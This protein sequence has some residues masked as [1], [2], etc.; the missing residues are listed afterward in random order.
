[1]KCH[2]DRVPIRFVAHHLESTVGLGRSVSRSVHTYGGKGVV[3]GSDQT[4][5]ARTH[6]WTLSGH[7]P[8]LFL[9]APAVSPGFVVALARYTESF[10]TP[11]VSVVCA[12]VPGKMSIPVS[13]YSIPGTVWVPCAA[14]LSTR[15]EVAGACGEWARNGRSLLEELGDAPETVC[16]KPG[17]V[18]KG[19]ARVMF[20]GAWRASHM[21]REQQLKFPSTISPQMLNSSSSYLTNSLRRSEA[22][23]LAHLFTF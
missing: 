7:F 18:P 3:K 5:L 11:V 15:Q 2:T 10:E 8:S 19:W 21:Y 14:V 20:Q 6:E 13:V 22:L 12:E 23:G 1:M 16:Q 9:E 4:A 17:Q